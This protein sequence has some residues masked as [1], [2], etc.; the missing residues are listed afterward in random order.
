MKV[1]VATQEKSHKIL[2]WE[3]YEYSHL[4][5]INGEKYSHTLGSLWELVSEIWEL[6]N[7]LLNRLLVKSP[8]CVSW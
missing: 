8:Y 2:E 6:R 1:V 7:F 3:K 4:Y 5:S